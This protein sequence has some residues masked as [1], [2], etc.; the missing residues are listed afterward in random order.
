[1]H[2]RQRG[3][4]AHG[5]LS[6]IAPAVR[7]AALAL[8]RCHR[9]WGANRVLTE[10]KREPRFDGQRLPSPSRLAVYFHEQCP[11]CLNAYPPRAKPATPP[12]HATAVH[13]IWQLDSQEAIRLADGT[14][15]TICNIRDPFGAAILASRAFAVTT[16]KHWR[17]LSLDEIQ[18]V[19]RGAF[20]SGRP[21]PTFSKPITNW[22]SRAAPWTPFR[23]ASRSG[24]L[25]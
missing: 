2:P 19:L 3:R 13:E 14:I 20:T 16:A 18:A 6:T 24:W 10:L 7:S 11:D 8:K 22:C 9:R 21:Y 1:M 17:K 4:P 25:D 23:A 12:P 15:A 5:T